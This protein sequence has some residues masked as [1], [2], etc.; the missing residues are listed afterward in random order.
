MEEEIQ[1]LEAKKKNIK[2]YPIYKMI[3]WDLL[4]YYSII[5]LFLTNVKN[6]TASQVLLADAFYPLFKFIFQ[7]PCT[8]L[9]ER[10]GKRKGLIIGN[11]LNAL[12]ILIF[13]FAKDFSY[14]VIANLISAI[15]FNIKGLAESTILYDSLS[16]FKDRPTR[17]SGI[18]GKGASFYYYINAISSI[19]TGF[20]FVVNGYLPLIICFAFCIISVYLSFKFVEINKPSKLS[21][22][23]SF[24]KY[25][26]DLRYSFKYIMR[27]SRLRS[28]IIFYSIVYGLLSVSVNLSSSLLK[29]I[30]V[31]EQYFGV[32]FGILGILCGYSAKK[33]NWFQNRYKNR[34]LTYISLPLVFAF[35][36]SGLV[37]VINAPLN[38]A[39]PI[40]LLMYSII[41]IVKGPFYTLG[42][43]YLNSF[44][45][46]A[47]RTKISSLTTLV[48]SVVRTI[49]SLF[50][51]F[52]LGFTT[53]A[54]VFTII[55]C[56]FTLIIM[57]LLKYM[58]TRVGLKPEEYKDEDIHFSLK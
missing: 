42:K 46:S 25:L 50:A 13:I 5:F 9:I 3:S 36:I 29:D 38:I 34:T 12:S 47:T 23:S 28:L 26:T 1:N 58:K 43:R 2:L 54:Y 49:I 52:L 16:G 18:E 31:P 41:H 15:G 10:L 55:G 45:D 20:L 33:Q 27:S 14:I 44:A 19:L 21:N 57:N 37:V 51:S 8:R 6:I 53:T 4:F 22:N 11:F 24:K 48:E 30:N 7:I 17:F 35:V 32:I 56:L 39:I 40:I